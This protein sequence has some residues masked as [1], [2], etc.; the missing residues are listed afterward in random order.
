VPVGVTVEG[1]MT[2]SLGQDVVIPRNQISDFERRQLNRPRTVGA[3]AG[4]VA[5]LVAAVFAYGE[6]VDNPEI[7]PPNAP[8]E[9]RIPLFSFQLW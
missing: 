4:G 7:P 3:V 8:D 5:A 2:R 6:I 1:A 9:I